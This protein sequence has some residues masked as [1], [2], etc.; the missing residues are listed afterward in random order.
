MVA[1]RQGQHDNDGRNEFRHETARSLGRAPGPCK[2]KGGVNAGINWNVYTA[3]QP[4]LRSAGLR[5]LRPASTCSWKSFLRITL[6]SG[7]RPVECDGLLGLR[8]E[9]SQLVTRQQAH[10]MDDA[11]LEESRRATKVINDDF[12]RSTA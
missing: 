5:R 10:G 8:A 11:K 12:R 4:A 7:N 1:G 2:G 3:S 9:A 6:T